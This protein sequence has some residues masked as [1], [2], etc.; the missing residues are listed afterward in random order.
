MCALTLINSDVII[1]NAKSLK[2]NIILFNPVLMEGYVDEIKYFNIF[3]TH[4]YCIKD[5]F[6]IMGKDKIMYASTV[7]MSFRNDYIEYQKMK[8][9]KKQMEEKQEEIRRN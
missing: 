9:Q 3:Q 6:T 2:N 1:C 7:D 4:M 5:N 8:I